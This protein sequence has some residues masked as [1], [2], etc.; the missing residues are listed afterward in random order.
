LAGESATWR[1]RRKNT[2][3]LQLANS[4]GKTLRNFITKTGAKLAAG[5][6]QYVEEGGGGLWTIS[7]VCVLRHRGKLILLCGT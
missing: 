5:N 3:E 7:M 2:V 1:S 6:L 4:D